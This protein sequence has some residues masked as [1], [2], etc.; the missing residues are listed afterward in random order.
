MEDTEATE[1]LSGHLISLRINLFPHQKFVGFG[2]LNGQQNFKTASVSYS[3][4]A[5]ATEATKGEF[6]LAHSWRLQSV[7]VGSHD[8]GA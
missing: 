6:V 4:P 5:V 3:L 1:S 8:A 7:M 2:Q